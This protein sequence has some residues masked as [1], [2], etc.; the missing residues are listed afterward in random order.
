MRVTT[1]VCFVLGLG[2]VISTG[3][4]LSACSANSDE[5]VG[6]AGQNGNPGGGLTG[7]G[8]LGG[9]GGSGFSLPDATPIGG[10]GGTATETTIPWPPPGFVNVTP[11]SIGDY[12]TS[13]E[14]LGSGSTPYTGSTNGDPRICSNILFGVVRDIKRGNLEGGHPD[15][16]TPRPGNVVK[17][18]VK[19]MLGDDGKPQFTD[20]DPPPSTTS[21]RDNFDQWYRNLDGVN[22]PYVV[23]LRFVTG[24][25]GVSTFAASLNNREAANPSTSYFPLDGLGFNDAAQGSDRNQHNFAFTTEL[26]TTFKYN[27]GET[28]KFDGDDDVW[29]FINKHLAIDLGGIHGQQSQT[30]NL[31]QQA[32]ALEIAKGNTY[33]LAVFNAERHTVQSN[34]RID[35]TMVFED[36]GI[37]PIL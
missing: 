11:V 9:N 34:F 2:S 3:L 6:A 28:F 13:T 19:D 1:T 20:A 12:A 33:D 22:I 21:N 25:N 15:F 8:P 10:Q 4:V 18:I 35:T 30:V 37:I 17:G 36:C 14:P 27:G 7:G 16:E 23:A 29:V 24:S 5:V 26:H 32:S 31:D